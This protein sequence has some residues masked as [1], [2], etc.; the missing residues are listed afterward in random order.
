MKPENLKDP[1][2]MQAIETVLRG[3]ARL[4]EPE[5]QKWV[6]MLATTAISVLHGTYGREFT[7]GYLHS[8]RKSLDDPSQGAP[9]EVIEVPHQKQ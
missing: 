9:I 7:A 1:V 2:E 3:I 4:K 5:R 6:T 8:A